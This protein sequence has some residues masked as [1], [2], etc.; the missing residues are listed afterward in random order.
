ME[1]EKSY[2]FGWYLNETDRAMTRYMYQSLRTIGLTRFHWQIMNRIHLSGLA[3]KE[4]LY[5]R[6]YLGADELNEVIDS[7]IGRGW[8]RI[9]KP[10]ERGETKLQFTDAGDKIYAKVAAKVKEAG[11]HMFA[12]IT[13]EEY[14]TTVNV[15]SRLIDHMNAKGFE[16]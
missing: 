15:L 13:K 5:A 11:V 9:V 3:V 4:K 10:S 1:G 12:P 2:G 16:G 6:H 8:V 14:E 7:L